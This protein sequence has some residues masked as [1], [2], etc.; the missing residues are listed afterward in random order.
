MNILKQFILHELDVSL[1]KVIYVNKVELWQLV[2]RYKWCE[3]TVLLH[4][5]AVQFNASTASD[6]LNS[7]F[8][9]LPGHGLCLHCPV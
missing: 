8:R 2:K 7:G 4:T 3:A 1:A 6:C 9:F 5:V